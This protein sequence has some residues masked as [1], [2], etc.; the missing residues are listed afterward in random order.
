MSNRQA[1]HV[2]SATAQS[3]GHDPSALV[4][5]RESFRK[6]RIKFRQLS[7]AEIKAAFSPDVPLTVHWDGKIVPAAD[8]A[9]REDRLPVLVSGD[10]VAKL[11][12]VPKLP[13]GTG[14]AAAT[15]VVEALK[16]WEVA[17]Q[18]VALCFDTT[19]SNTG[20]ASGA[21]T[22]IEQHLGREVLHLACR[23]HIFE[24]V[25]EKAYV[26]CMGPTSGPDVPLFK[27]L[28]S[29]W[30]SIDLE[31]WEPVADDLPP[32][33]RA[34]RDDR[35]AAFHSHLDAA[36]P[37][38]D[39]RELLELS[40]ILLGGVP[41]RGIR[42]L[43]PGALHHAR[44]MAKLIYGLKIYIFR[45]QLKLNAR[46][47]LGLSRFVLF[48]VDVYIPAWF[49]APLA[50]SAPAHDLTFA[51]RLVGYHD[52]GVAEATAKVF[53]R[54]LWYLSETLVA[55]AFFDEGTSLSTKRE[56]VKALGHQGS[57]DPPRRITLKMESDV[58]ANMSLADFVTS[59]SAKFFRA[60][61]ISTE[62]LA[63]DP[64]DWNDTQSYVTAV[65][66]VE[67]LLVVNDFAERGV[68]MMQEFNLFLTK[69][70]DQKQF[71]LQ[72]VEDHRHKYPNA[73]K[74]TVTSAS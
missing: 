64:A 48:A 21:C 43:R 57:D 12:A 60:M 61:D 66:R 26:E 13:N 54:H 55:L 42:F 1:V 15:A 17:D 44:W 53:G 8:G 32:D 24:L 29:V 73:R 31:A 18:V 23:H 59:A 27:R 6:E 65:R 14:H 20:M 22:L 71:L 52:T 3:L 7:A 49:V 33:L 70:E 38:D 2:L 50:V 63:S 16:D 74:S 58:I 68:A 19:S 28:K 69:T 5:N 41:K 39:Y 36:Q 4:M 34:K 51:K 40:I 9:S 37:R 10:G 35:I 25:A 46:E 56:M 47:L 30:A 67:A 72:V 62:F 45:A 11:L